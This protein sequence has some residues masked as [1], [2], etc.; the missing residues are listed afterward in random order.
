MISSRM[1]ILLHNLKF[2]SNYRIEDIMWTEIEQIKKA[3]QYSNILTHPRNIKIK[4]LNSEETIDKLMTDPKSFYRY[5]DGEIEIMLGGAAGTQS[6]DPDLA[7]LLRE[8]LADASIDAYIGIGYD[9]FCFDIWNN[10]EFS[11]RFYLEKGDKYRE[12]YIQNCNEQITYIDTGF[13][14][15][16]FNLN[17]EELE[18]W[19]NKLKSL[20][21]KKRITLFMGE[22]AYNNLDY[23][24]FEDA[25]AIEFIPCKSK[26][27]F[28]DYDKILTLARS[29]PK[30][31]IICLA[32]GATAKVV[33][34]TLTKEGYL[35]YDIGHMPKDYDSYRKGIEVNSKNALNFYQED[36]KLK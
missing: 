13:S 12:F 26:D 30:N 32:I 24:V 34:Y 36:Y 29:R 20:F 14:Q 4:I 31:E 3:I 18:N 25:E 23:Y 7:R 22:A 9:Y 16:Y 15:R 33:A 19:F 8:A 21:K 10:T 1:R 27:A 17:K 28:L 6:Y 35:C 2:L 11:N 5:G